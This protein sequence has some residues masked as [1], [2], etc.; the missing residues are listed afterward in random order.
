MDNAETKFASRISRISK[1]KIS[2]KVIADHEEITIIDYG[3]ALFNYLTLNVA[4]GYDA[5]FYINLCETLDRKIRTYN[6]LVTTGLMNDD[7]RSRHRLQKS[8][9]QV[10]QIHPI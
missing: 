7:K 4:S 8:T 9:I 5:W 1:K 6:R 3:R 10:Q 2:R